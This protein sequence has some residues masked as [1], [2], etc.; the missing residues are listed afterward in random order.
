M[1]KR[2]STFSNLL[3]GNLL[4]VA[5]VST[6]LLGAFWIV[7]EMMRY[8]AETEEMRTHLLSERKKQLQMA[9]DGAVD[10]VEF[11][12]SQMEKKS[13]EVLK[14][15]V[16]EAHQL[17]GQLYDH[18]G[19]TKSL[20]EVTAIIREALRPI[21][22]HDGRG[23]Y[24]AIR[25]DGVEELCTECVEPEHR[26]VLDIQDSNGVFVIREMIDLVRRQEQGFYS[27][28]WAKP[29]T[30]GRDHRKLSY[31]RYF[32]P[33]DWL[34]GTG[35]YLEDMENDLKREALGWLRSI[36][37]DRGGYVFAGDWH[38][39]SLAGPSVGK[40]MIDTEDVNGVRFVREMVGVAR[41]GEGFLEYVMPGLDNLPSKPKI[42]YVKGVAD[43][44]WYI[45][46][47]MYIDDIEAA[48]ERQR[49]QAG[50]RLVHNIVS[51][52]LIL[53]L[54][55]IGVFFLVSRFNARV[56]AML[57]ACTGFFRHEGAETESDIPL[58]NINIQEFRELALA[59]DRIIT[60]RNRA[61]RSLMEKSEEL[62]RYFNLSLDLLCIADREGK[63]LRVNPEWEKVLG[64]S[65]AE[66]E[67]IRFLDLVH[68]DDVPAT[69]AAMVD[70]DNQLSVN[71]F[72]NRYRCRNGSYRW[73]EWR[74]RQPQGQPIYGIARDITS[75]KK[76]ELELRTS[77][78]LLS[79]FIHNSPVY[80]FI[81]E[82]DA[83]ASRTLHASENYVDMVGIP[84][85]QME[86]K[87]M[88]ELFPPDFAAKITADDQHV[89]QSGEVIRLDEELNGRSYTTIKFPIQIGPDSYLAGYTI[90]LTERI[91]AE[92]ALAESE[93]T[94]R[95]IV[96]A[97]PM[98]IHLYE[99]RAGQLIFSGTNPA[100]G[101]ILGVDNSK[102]IGLS[103]GEAFPSLLATEIPERYRRCAEKGESWQTEQVV[104]A[105]NGITGAFEV[106]V[107]Q[108]SPGR[109]AVLFHDITPRKLAEQDKERLQSQLT[110]AQKIESV[111][112]LAGGV[113]HDFNNMLGVIIGHTELAVKLL[114]PDNPV[115]ANLLNIRKAAD[116]S[117]DLTRQLLAFARK[118]TVSPQT[119]DLNETVDGMLSMLQ[120]LIG[121][122][123]DLLWSPGAALAAVRIDPS[124]LDQILVNLCVNARD[125]IHY[126]GKITIETGMA[127]ISERYCRERAECIPGSYVQ[128]CVSDTG[129]GMD[130]RT[131]DH[132]FEP[133]FTTKQ[134]GKGT[135]LGLATVYG[136]IK[137]N[138]GFINVY[139][140][141]DVGTT[142]KV[143]FPAFLDTVGGA[144]ERKE[145]NETLVGHE[146]I[147]LVE[148]EAQILELT[149]TILKDLGYTVLVAGSPAEALRLAEESSVPIDLLLTDV[150]MP[151]MHGRDLAEKLTEM[152]P[153][154]RSL[155]MSGYPANVIAHHGILEENI[156]FIQKPFSSSALSQK[157][158][159]VFGGRSSRQR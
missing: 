47:G 139:S 128:L 119:L 154:L 93:E 20:E 88:E 105:E 137:Q 99:L 24:F 84:G 16:N 67:S 60:D 41:Q 3:L 74:S 141:P 18:F 55:W 122:D 114:E 102:F 146:T 77:N 68:P 106:Y 61:I 64:Y 86:G 29:A 57:R 94:F 148:D 36:K 45:G 135:G 97:S 78:E 132:L 34:I 116:R 69:K 37:D 15:R 153:G 140:E 131:M 149:T 52:C 127:E 27:Y 73:L 144:G 30:P 156:F 120:R 22:F 9:V 46:T 59:A 71:N 40:N 44:Q 2:R 151:E 56:Q 50:R 62:E 98:G 42:S 26:N 75:R 100:A 39:V 81:K 7:Q 53:G 23:Y 103:I 33:L 159:Q 92:L 87:T 10:Y 54:L 76:S 117:T 51:I 58:E 6:L 147:L 108:I 1:V 150:V 118:Q 152:Q 19:A 79:A 155:F 70:L 126:S 95:N 110:Q 14:E 83:V 136:I 82:V 31:V 123:I 11:M 142:F 90:D 138:N 21:R 13:R 104:Y 157:L 109:I 112:R 125:A 5:T 89:V 111:G 115:Q 17:A 38:G 65:I 121:E 113:A 72:E 43:W 85:S 96:Q 80:A 124:Q 12:R 48:V 134:K 145:S 107:F 35:E 8:R 32:A 66:L 25:L 91:Q 133:F 129:Q 49:H 101:K 63:F 4:L 143:Y 158:R 28:S 130:E